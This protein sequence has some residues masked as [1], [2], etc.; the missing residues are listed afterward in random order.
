MR[1]SPTFIVVIIFVLISVTLGRFLDSKEN[2]I[3]LETTRIKANLTIIED[4][5]DVL[6][7][8]NATLLPQSNQPGVRYLCM[9]TEYIYTGKM[10]IE[11]LK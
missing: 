9:G 8:D 7:F 6:R 3:I 11:V 2:N 4:G 1:C 5:V 10:L